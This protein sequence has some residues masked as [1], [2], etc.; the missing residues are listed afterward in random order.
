MAET[1]AVFSH[2]DDETT[3]VIKLRTVQKVIGYFNE[4]GVIESTVTYESG[5]VGIGHFEWVREPDA[6]GTGVDGM[7]LIWVFT[8]PT[9][10]EAG[11]MQISCNVNGMSLQGAG[12]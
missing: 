7:T 3:P 9:A 10:I 4:Q 2:K 12:G 8:K 11:T 6:Y 5:N 1:L